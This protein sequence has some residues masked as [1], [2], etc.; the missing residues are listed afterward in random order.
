MQRRCEKD[1]VA[2]RPP[3]V[4]AGADTNVVVDDNPSSPKVLGSKR[5]RKRENIINGK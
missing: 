3:T 5:G 4:K 1:R 2:L